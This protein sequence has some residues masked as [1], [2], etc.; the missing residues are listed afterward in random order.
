MIDDLLDFTASES[1]LGKPVGS[2]LRDGKL[3]LPAI[4]LMGRG[5][6]H[7]REYVRSVVREGFKSVSPDDIVKAMQ[8]YELLERA[9]QEAN[10]YA[11]LALEATESLPDSAY[12]D[13]L[14]KIANFVVDR[15]L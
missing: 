14:V 7:E 2:D 12:R 6:D 10:R 3:T 9:H 5:A 4:W 13:A 15:D 1:K 8:R 11:K